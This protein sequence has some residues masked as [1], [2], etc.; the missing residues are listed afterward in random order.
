MKRTGIWLVLVLLSSVFAN[1]QTDDY[2]KA[3]VF[4]GYSNNRVDSGVDSSANFNGFINDRESYHGANVSAVYNISRFVGFKADLSA[5]YN[6][7]NFS[8]QVPSSGTLAFDTKNSLYNILGG[9]QIKDNS[10]GKRFKPFVHALI[11]AGHGRTRVSNLICPTG[12]SCAGIAGGSETGFAGAFGG[13]LDIKLSE[14]VDFRVVQVDYNPIKFKDGVQQ[15]VRI[16]I[17]FVFK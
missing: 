5:A 6:E 2:K 10:T 16:G 14:H 13:G 3:E 8:L 17:G 1:A 4:V 7:R 11:G 9:I 12:V 15:N